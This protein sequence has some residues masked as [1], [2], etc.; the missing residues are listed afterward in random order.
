MCGRFVQSSPGEVVA[1]R[2]GLRAVPPL[3]PRFNVAPTQ[4]AAVIREVDGDRRADLLRFGLVPGW[5]TDPRVGARM[6]NARAERIASAPAFRAAFQRR[7]CL[8]PVDGFYEWRAV[9]RS[10]QPWLVRRE[11][12]GL[13]ALAGVWERFEP[14]EGEPFESFAIVTT[15]ASESLRELHDRM[16]A[17][18]EAPDEARWLDPANDD[19]DGLRA[20]LRPSA[21][22]LE[23]F[24]VSRAVNDARHDD[25]SLVE[26][27]AADD[28]EVP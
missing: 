3:Q 1:K 24:P 7:R 12:G 25:P 5:A 9:G 16:P 15:E 22:T 13:L 23:R 28:E 26:P 10:K 4:P 14:A 11:G 19:R 20:L 18:I 8:V 21:A 17:V 27:A 6:I 2:F